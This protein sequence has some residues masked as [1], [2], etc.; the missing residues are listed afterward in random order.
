MRKIFAILVL[1]GAMMIVSR[2]GATPTFSAGPGYVSYP[3]VTV[4]GD[5]VAYSVGIQA[6]DYDGEGNLYIFSLNQIIKNP[7]GTPEVLFNYQT[8]ATIYGSFV[9]VW[10]DTV[11]FGESSNGT[12]QS[13]PVGGGSASRLFSIPGYKGINNSLRLGIN[14][15]LAGNFDCSFNSQSQMFLSA[16]PGGFGAAE[17]KIYYWDGWMDPVIIADMGKYSGPFAFDRNDDLYYG[18][19]G[20]PAG[21]ENVVYF[22]ATQ[23]ANAV[24]SKVPLSSSDWNIYASGVDA[25]SGLAFDQNSPVQNIYTS[26]SLGTVTGIS[27][28]G[29]IYKYGSCSSPS[30][31][32]FASGENDYRDFQ[33]GGGRLFVLGT[34]WMDSSSTIFAV[35]PCPQNFVLGS[36]DYS[37]TGAS[38]IAVFRPDSGLWAIRDLT[39]IYFGG[40]GD[41]PVAGDYDGDGISDPSIYRPES[42]LWAAR[43]VTRVYFGGAQDIPLPRDYDGDGT[44][45]SAIFRPAADL[46]AVRGV[47]RAYFGT[48]GDFPQPDYNDGAIVLFRPSTGLWAVRDITR[49]YF[50]A[51]GDLPV[52]GDYDGDSS[53]DAGIYRPASGL[54]AIRGVTR[55]YFGSGEEWDVPIPLDYQGNGS[56]VPAIFRPSAGLWA[57]HGVTRVYFGNEGDFPAT[58]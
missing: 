44:V 50:G 14:F 9:K 46:W 11:Y 2:V 36:G 3:V 47:T 39:R 16:N 5:P 35:K 40:D 8:T 4:D 38:D 25:C 51:P 52:P 53:T 21:P 10:G 23:V 15:Y 31:I 56:V 1:I 22:T 18:F 13:V 57:I 30:I 32:K 43:G 27:G 28:P 37:I 7:A 19:T 29:D 48:D 6:F 55:V 42:G 54:W 12:V 58:R 17:N 45:D 24:S 34:D 26:S 20:Y 33:P 49:F 41:L